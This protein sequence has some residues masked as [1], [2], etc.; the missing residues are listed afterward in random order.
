MKSSRIQ[1]VD[2]FLYLEIGYASDMGPAGLYEAIL[3]AVEKAGVLAEANVVYVRA[4]AIP[5]RTLEAV[6]LWAPE[7]EDTMP[8][9]IPT[10][11]CHE[12]PPPNI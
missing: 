3:E 2:R 6:T 10:H 5:E 7:A 8:P 11:P 12:Q 1:T 9:L 4:R